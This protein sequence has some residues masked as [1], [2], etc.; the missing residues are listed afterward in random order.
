V[1]IDSFTI[2][3]DQFA[4]SIGNFVFPDGGATFRLLGIALLI[5]AA[6]RSRFA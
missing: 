4:I 5:L 2:A 6:A 1:G 3:S